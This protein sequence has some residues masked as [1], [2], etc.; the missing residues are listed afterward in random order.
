MRKQRQTN[1]VAEKSQWLLSWVSPEYSDVSDWYFVRVHATE[2]QNA[3]KHIN[4]SA[5]QMRYKYMSGT[6]ARIDQHHPRDCEGNIVRSRTPPVL[7]CRNPPN[8]EP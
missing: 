7:Q 3:M 2:A 4:M 6:P 1:I 8:E 5:L